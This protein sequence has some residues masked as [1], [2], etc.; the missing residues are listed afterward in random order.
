[1]K[2]ASV[3]VP[4]FGIEAEVVRDGRPQLLVSMQTNTGVAFLSLIK[5]SLS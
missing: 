5:R 2:F 1:M 3:R 4:K